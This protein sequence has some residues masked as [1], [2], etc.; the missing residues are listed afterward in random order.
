MSRPHL[1]EARA[2]GR[3]S[4]RGVNVKRARPMLHN[5]PA[6]AILHL[7]ELF[8]IHSLPPA[9]RAIALCCHAWKD[10]L[11]AD[12]YNAVALRFSG[13][14]AA[15]TPPR[16]S[17]RLV[18][19]PLVGC[20]QKWMALRARSEALHHALASAG[21]DSRDLSVRKVKKWAARHHPTLVDRVSPVYDATLLMEVC[22]A[23]GVGE[24]T[25][26]QVATALIEEMGA[27]AAR[28]NDSGLSPLIIA[29]AR[30]LPKM[31]NLLLENGAEYERPGLG[32]FRLADSRQSI[33][34]RHS[35]LEWVEL[36]LR[37]EAAIG[38]APA[39]QKG[40]NNCLGRLRAKQSWD[41][42][43][44]ERQRK[45]SAMWGIFD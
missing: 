36:L 17:T 43:D 31:V 13:S 24:A 2:L 8:S 33:R 38:V 14:A 1:G 16:A 7:L 42:A 45:F 4:S 44:P 40:L 15:G 25:M 9:L 32:R 30:G 6:D 3:N 37:E 23:R 41:Q 5:L 10:S 35:A 11:T 22:K 39:Q 26:V 28:A 19:T 21:Q 29:A 27:S 12:V 20:G 34:G 18:V